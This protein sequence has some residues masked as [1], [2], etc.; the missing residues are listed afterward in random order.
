MDQRDTAEIRRAA[1]IRGRVQGVSFRWYTREEAERLG[2][3]GWV[4]NDADGTVRL[5]VQGDPHDVEALLRW[6]R[7]GP[8][9]ARVDDL[10]VE[11]LPVSGAGAGFAI[12]R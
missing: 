4:R 9:Q 11:D 7:D 3:T 2:V 5:E 8:P 10:V 12:V 6:C 1:T